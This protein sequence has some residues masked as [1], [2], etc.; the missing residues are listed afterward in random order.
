MKN[1]KRQKQILS[2]K[3]L[4]KNVSGKKNCDKEI[5][6]SDLTYVEASNSVASVTT[7]EEDF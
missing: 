4:F 6:S 5:N 1:Y 2:V 3:K 7:P